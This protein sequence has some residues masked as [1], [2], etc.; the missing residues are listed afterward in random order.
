MPRSARSGSRNDALAR[1]DKLLTADERRLMASLSTPA[2]IQE[3]LDGAVYS[4][5][6]FYRCP[7]RV[8][9]DRTAHCFDGALFAAAALR[10]IG[11]PPLVLELLPNERDDDHMLALF[12]QDGT[13]GAIAK[14]NFSGLRYREPIHRTLRELALT[15]FEPFY[16]VL[17][18]KTLRAY[19]RPLD[20]A[21]FDRLD[22]MTQDAPLDR[23]ADH[24]GT[25]KPV[26]LLTPSMI[27]GLAPVDERTYRTGLEGS[28]EAGLWKPRE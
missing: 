17:R 26:P 7:L 12:R 24:L 28:V 25:L 5:D 19:T 16:N 6:P 27:R 8:I 1:F 2:R 10:R 14:S 13:W 21:R 22:W 18:E 9:R 15:Y 11:H 3:F 4:S 23:I 20:L